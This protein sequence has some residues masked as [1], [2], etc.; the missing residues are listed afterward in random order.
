MEQPMPMV[1]RIISKKLY[2]NYELRKTLDDIDLTLL[3]GAY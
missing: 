3:M 1:E 2:G